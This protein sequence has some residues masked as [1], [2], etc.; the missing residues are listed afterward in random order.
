MGPHYQTINLFLNERILLNLN[1]VKKKTFFVTHIYPHTN[2][3]H[4]V[5]IDLL[6]V[7]IFLWL[8]I[9]SSHLAQGSVYMAQVDSSLLNKT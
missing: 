9:S 6:Y 4:N 8:P 1:F 5:S 7:F 2:N 3:L